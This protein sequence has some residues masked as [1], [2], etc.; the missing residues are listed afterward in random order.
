[1]YFQNLCCVYISLC[2]SVTIQIIELRL[3]PPCILFIKLFVHYLFIYLFIDA[4]KADNII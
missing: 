4:A 3:L 1:M 2:D